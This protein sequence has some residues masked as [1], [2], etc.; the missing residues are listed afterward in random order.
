MRRMIVWAVA[1]ATVVCAG[2]ALAADVDGS[3]PPYAPA[4]SR[5]TPLMFSY[6]TGVYLG[7]HGGWGWTTSSNV[8]ASGVFGG[9]Q[10]GYNYQM[11]RFLLGIEGDGA[12]AHINQGAKGTAF[13]LPFS[14]SFDVDGLASLRA[15]FGIGFDN[16]L[17]YG[18]AGGGWGHGKISAAALGFNASGDAWH[19]GWTAGAGIEYGIV[20]NWSVKLEYLHYGLGSATD[21]GT[22]NTGNLNIETFKIGVNY[23]FH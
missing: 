8:D 6:W 2:E 9:G 11:G 7:A 22:L 23:L 21:F 12:F 14:A 5:Y 17:F 15:R 16:V 10:I 3:F 20:P 19:S 1:M 13:G 4:P 18:T